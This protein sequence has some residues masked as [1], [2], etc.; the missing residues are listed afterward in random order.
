MQFFKKARNHLAKDLDD[1]SKTGLVFVKENV[2]KKSYID[3]RDIDQKDMSV[4][5]P[6]TLFKQ[7]FVKAGFVILDEFD[8]EGFPSDLHDVKCFVLAPNI[9]NIL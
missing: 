2:T 7:I 5:R 3:H 4:I 9:K 8:Q 6:F 1:R